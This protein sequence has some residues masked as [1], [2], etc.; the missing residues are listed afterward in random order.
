WFYYQPA[1]VNDFER[2]S[3]GTYLLSSI[4]GAASE[5][6]TINA[7]ELGLG[8]EDYKRRYTQSGRSTLH[9]T[10]HCSKIQLGKIAFRYHAAQFVNRSPRLANIVHACRRKVA[11][12]S[13]NS[14]IPA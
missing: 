14:A 10:A 12:T 4:I 11:T 6:P 5:D 3:P 13:R 1:F 7:V 2:L 8:D 9:V